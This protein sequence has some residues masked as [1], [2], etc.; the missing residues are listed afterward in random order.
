M[1]TY[2]LARGKDLNFIRWSIPMSQVLWKTFS[3]DVRVTCNTLFFQFDLN[4]LH[5]HLRYNLL[6]L[7]T[8]HSFLFIS[9][10]FAKQY[11]VYC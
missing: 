3:S 5:I 9:C 4:G 11:I 6:R 7:V 8:T 10:S 1:R 2:P